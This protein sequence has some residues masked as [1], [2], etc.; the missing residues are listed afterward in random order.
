MSIRLSVVVVCSAFAFGV[1]GQTLV[2]F[3]PSPSSEP[4]GL[5]W[6]GEYL[7]CADA[8]TDSIYQLDPNSGR[9]TSGF[10]FNINGSFGGLT[11]GNDS[12]IWLANGPTVYQLNASTGEILDGFSCPGG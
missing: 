9:V 8:K 12:T 6:D 5:A 10:S 4:R 1:G 3:F 2:D 7:W 11:W